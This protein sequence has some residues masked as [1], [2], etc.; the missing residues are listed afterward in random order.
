MLKPDVK[1][2]LASL[3]G[4]PILF[5]DTPVS[6]LGRNGVYDAVGLHLTRLGSSPIIGPSRLQIQPITSKGNLGR[7]WLEIPLAA[8][9]NLI[10]ALQDFLAKDRAFAVQHTVRTS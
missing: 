3:P 2:W 8:V 1:Q 5:E 4:Q 6:F 9:P 10:A 7:A